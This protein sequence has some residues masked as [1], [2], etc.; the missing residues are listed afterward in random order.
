[1]WTNQN[2]GAHSGVVGVKLVALYSGN[3][4]G[5][6]FN[7]RLQQS[8][9]GLSLSVTPYTVVTWRKRKKKAGQLHPQLPPSWPRPSL[10]FPGSH[11]SRWQSRAPPAHTKAFLSCLPSIHRDMTSFEYISKAP[12]SLPIIPQLF[13]YSQPTQASLRPCTLLPVFLIL[14][15][16]PCTAARAMDYKYG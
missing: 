5:C 4:S 2:L 3:R 12:A 10:P 6:E 8:Q 1:M 7:L 15:Q 13:R 11:I 9:K 14:P 16:H